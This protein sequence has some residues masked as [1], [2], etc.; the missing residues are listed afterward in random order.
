[1]T[2]RKR[3][4]VTFMALAMMAYWAAP[5]A[6]Q[7]LYGSITGLIEDSS[8]G[9][10]PNA[11]ISI[12][13]KETGQ[14]Y[15][16]KSDE[17]GRYT[18]QNIL[19]G[20]YDVKISS[21]GFKAETAKNLRVAAG[22]VTRQ[23]AKLQVGS[24]S[25]V[26]E[27][28]AEVAVLQTDK[29]DTHTELNSQQISSLPLPGYRNY[30]SLINLVPGATPSSFQNS[31]TD[32]PGRSL[33]TN[34]NGTN[35]N[36]NMTRIDG[37]AS[38][39]LWLPHHTG[40]VMPAEMV[41]TVNVT[42]AASDAEQ[43]TA[44]GA[45]I[46]LVTKSGTNQFHG[47]LFEFHDNDHLKAR[48]FF[49]AVKPLRIYNNYGAT[50]GGPI[51]KNKL[52]FFYSFD[53]SRQRDGAFGTY[54]VPT[55]DIRTGN[56]ASTGT[57]IFDPATG[58][59]TNGVGRTP[60]PANMIP[61]NRISPQAAKIQANYPQ[62][63]KA[64]AL[65]NYDAVGGP[66]FKRDYNDVKI[67][68]T[69]N[70]RSQVWGHYGRMKALVS[71]KA[72][73]GDGVGPSPGAD[74]GTGNTRV[75]NMSAGHN[76]TLSANLLL[77]GVFGYQRQD[78][79]VRGVDFGKDFST[80]LGIPGINNPADI[81]QSGFPNIS[82]NGYNGFGVPG[83]MP[84]N[85]VEESYTTSH[86]LRYLKGAHSFSFGFD[87]VNHR[88]THYQ[89]ELG[90]GPRGAFDFAGGPTVLGPSGA[91]NNFNGYAAFLLGLTNN[92]QKSIQYILMTPREYQFGWYAQDRWQVTKRLTMNFGLRYELYPLM[93][94][95][96]GKGIERLEPLTNQVFLGGRGNQPKDVGV[97]VSHK[98]FAPKVG[99]AYRIDD[100]TVF[101][102]GYGVNF[103][104]LP[105]SRPLRGFYPLT[106][107]FNF[108]APN[109]FVP[110]G[111][112]ATGLPPTVG[113]DISSGIV[114]LPAVADMRSPNLG[115]IHRGYIQSWNATFERRLP[116][117]VVVTVAYVGTQTV[118][119]LADLD[120]NSSSPGLGNAGRPYNAKFGRTIATNMWDGYLSSHYHSLQTSL[121]KQFSKGVMLQGSY[122]YSKAINMT[123]EDGW[124]GVGWNWAPVFNRNRALAGYDRTQIFNLG[125]V[126]ELPF[127]KGKPYA[128]SGLLAQIVGGWSVN[129]IMA[130]YTG[131]PFTV[132]ASGASLNIGGGNAQTA[133]QVKSEV[134]RSF[135]VGPGTTWYDTDAFVPVTTT[136][137]GSTG[138]NI[139]RNPGVWN[140]DLLVGRTFAVTERVKVEFRG[141]ATNFPNTS[142][143][144]GFA[145]T[146]VANKGNNFL[147]VRSS[148]GE[149]Q[150][151]FGLRVQF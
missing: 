15:E 33:R 92:M 70:E 136:R 106:V 143:F 130:A 82:I 80:A 131:T 83:W 21:S 9:L 42:T 60:F 18:L 8:G 29:S 12:S 63:N 120:I 78:Q 128:S 96:T 81:M 48:N 11:T 86:N 85:R 125:W 72:I 113:P 79:T 28:Q 59:V 19:P 126:Y 68:W 148:F 119:Q 43:G 25:E 139:L 41:S 61:A 2:M 87:G 95:A 32:S 93:T 66:N 88:M 24:V 141:E 117:S 22:F 7:M 102:A 46:T 144:G 103:D 101:R 10:V 97:S 108:D 23:N 52:F 39:N 145:S 112:L 121:R 20:E 34:I 151:R 50:I 118:H 62:P 64:G 135:Q 138:R 134:A 38:V 133:D 57:T 3:F 109:A 71:G 16:A 17:G 13:N 123:D 73:F 55:A 30:Q 122:T 54:S 1:M 137:F 94:R 49:A 150:V 140:T 91:A 110:V 132:G 124:A 31:V 56:F 37:A 98:L 129:G 146:S 84:L 36:N 100:K 6:A 127:G 90:A 35:A 40:Y 104:P 65:T 45:G 76:Y 107:N 5:A 114:N 44:G 27:V 111:N 26:I 67:N 105:F 116:Q 51:K 69:R 89:P 4:A 147:S 53:G 142:H 58:N 99:L 14:T 75:Q 74:P 77:D 115:Q 149:R 47:S